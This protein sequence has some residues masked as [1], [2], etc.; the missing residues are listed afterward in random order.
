[1]TEH[2]GRSVCLSVCSQSVLWQ[3]G[4]LD[5]N[6]VW[7]GKWGRSTYGCIRRGGDRRREGAV[8]D[9]NLGRPIVTKGDFAT[10]LF[11]SY[12]GQYLFLFN[13]SDDLYVIHVIARLY[14]TTG[15]IRPRCLV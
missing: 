3:N 10:R 14:C 8:L 7:D 2:V 9:L 13:L 11:P 1:M 15:S 5:P 6:A 4:R 12:F